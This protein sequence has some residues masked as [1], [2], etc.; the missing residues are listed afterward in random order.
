MSYKTELDRETGKLR[1]VFPGQEPAQQSAKAF[2]A[3]I[4]LAELCE[5][6]QEKLS[7]AL[8][9]ANPATD[10]PLILKIY[11]ELKDRRDGKPAQTVT[12]TT[13]VTVNVKLSEHRAR[14]MLEAQQAL[15][16]L[17]LIDVTP[18]SSET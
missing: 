16:N 12:Q 8:Q 18:P 15:D 3:G 1:K 6:A 11:A 9:A 2:V 17:L 5:L 14:A 4:P 7:E 10:A 13:D